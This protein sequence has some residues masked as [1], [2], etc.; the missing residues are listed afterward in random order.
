METLRL[1]RRSGDRFERFL[2]VADA[3][4]FVVVPNGAST[5]Y[6]RTPD[7]IDRMPDGSPVLDALDGL[8]L[9]PNGRPAVV[10]EAFGVGYR[11]IGGHAE[12]RSDAWAVSSVYAGRID[13]LFSDPTPAGRR[14][15][16][17]Y[18]VEAVRRVRWVF[19]T[20]WTEGGVEACRYEI[21]RRAGD[22]Q[23]AVQALAET[24]D[25]LDESRRAYAEA[26]GAPPPEPM[27][28]PI[29][30]LGEPYALRLALDG[31]RLSRS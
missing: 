25:A 20:A 15:L 3:W 11:N 6:V 29:F 14:R 7:H 21:E 4:T 23:R 26:S 13:A 9:D 16:G 17:E 24:L 1:A 5:A 2:V 22:V 8:R 28:R 18:I 19:P 31:G 10:V 30:E 12:W 27:A